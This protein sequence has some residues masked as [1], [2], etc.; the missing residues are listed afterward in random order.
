[1]RLLHYELKKIWKSRYAFLFT[2]LALFLN[3]FLMFIITSPSKGVNSVHAYHTLKEN[4]QEMDEKNKSDFIYQ[5]LSEAQQAYQ[6]TTSVEAG[7]SL[8]K[9]FA[10]IG[11]YNWDESTLCTLLQPVYTNSLK[12]DYLFLKKV[13]LELSVLNNY[14]KLLDG[15]DERANKLQSISI[16]SS[17][18]NTYEKLSIL[19]YQKEYQKLH[20]LKIVF[21]PQFG[22]YT[23]TSSY[24]TDV[25]IIVWVFFF[26]SLLRHERDARLLNY[27]QTL[28]N[29]RT[30]TALA[31]IGA[32]N[33]SVF[34]ST[35]LLYGSNFLYCE[36]LYDLG[37]LWRSIQSVP[38]FNQST[39]KISVGEYLFLYLLVK[40]VVAILIG[41]FVMLVVFLPQ[42]A[43]WGYL[44]LLFFFLTQAITYQVIS[45]SG[46]WNWLKYFNAISMLKVNDSVGT[47]QLVNCFGVPVSVR[48]IH[49][50]YGA[51]M[52]ITTE[53]G[54]ILAFGRAKENIK[55]SKNAPSKRRIYKLGITGYE[56]YKQLKL[57]GGFS[58]LFLYL[59]IQLYSAFGY[60]SEITLLEQY[61]KE[62]ST[63]LTGPITEQTITSF[64]EKWAEVQ[65]IIKLEWDYK[66]KVID[67]QTYT[68]L[69]RANMPLQYKYQALSR[70]KGNL[71]SAV[72]RPRTAI[73]YEPGWLHFLGVEKFDA[74]RESLLITILCVAGLAYGFSNEKS[75]GIQQYFATMSKGRKDFW[76][77][78]KRFVDLFSL[79]IALESF[80]APFIQSFMSSGLPQWFAPVYS[81]SAF[82]WMPEFPLIFL[83]LLIFLS[84]FVAIRVLCGIIV[85][86][87]C[88][89]HKPITALF[90]SFAALDFTLLLSYWEYPQMKW[91]SIFPMIDS[92]R[93]ISQ[94]NQWSFVLAS[95]FICVA[96]IY[97]C[98]YICEKEHMRAAL[99]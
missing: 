66:N 84:R 91:L 12:D 64:Q 20:G 38:V 99:S 34:C 30:R 24:L 90:L 70:I 16:F 71:I 11:R 59:I 28:P 56:L 73:L 54:F 53:G 17:A 77:A 45:G 89:V 5:E 47:Y 18:P 1:M 85:L 57:Y 37:P 32:I 27:I 62:Y 48:A 3:L 67:Y 36:I 96:G 13:S 74:Q 10:L 22:I 9:A 98:N 2:C 4:I 76:K 81:I 51:I 46:K 69:I 35:I 15:I 82:S 49:L 8:D 88:F 23:A 41:D 43:H 87:S 58:I 55:E 97:L 21:F 83:F 44:V 31:K 19:K 6:L 29:G 78:R 94:S 25:I 86:I 68:E 52:L 26:A 95:S 93:L 75:V 50:I 60:A 80:V 42:K 14:T 7:L 63:S 40:C 92:G 79:I 39:L 65:P 72:N 33:L 61:Y